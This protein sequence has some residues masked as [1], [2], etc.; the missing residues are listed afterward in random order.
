M[1]VEKILSNKKEQLF[2]YSLLVIVFII[3]IK[4]IY[5]IH[6]TTADDVLSEVYQDILTLEDAIDKGV[7]IT[8]FMNSFLFTYILNF[9]LFLLNLTEFEVFLAKAT[10]ILSHIMLI[11]SI[12][13]R[14]LKFNTANP[15]L[16]LLCLLSVQNYW[17][18]HLVSAFPVIGI[19]FTILLISLLLFLS[20]N[21]Y[22]FLIIALVE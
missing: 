17:E 18:H 20:E 21:I 1:I 19:A 10:I 9:Y 2:I 14:S 8:Y 11:T 5:G 15:L 16:F 3:S 4:E 12:L 22:L 7:R 6:Y 13:S